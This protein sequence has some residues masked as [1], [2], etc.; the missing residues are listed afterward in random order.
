MVSW[1]KTLVQRLHHLARADRRLL[2]SA[3]SASVSAE[4]GGSRPSVDRGDTPVAPAGVDRRQGLHDIS[5]AQRRVAGQ[6][7]IRAFVERDRLGFDIELDVR[8]AL[9][10]S[11]AR[12]RSRSPQACVP[13]VKKRSAPS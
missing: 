13:M 4:I 1:P 3:L 10:A 7:D 11:R 6:R 9:W 5:Q 8:D 12:R 2:A